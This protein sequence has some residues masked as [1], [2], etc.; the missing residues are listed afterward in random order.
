M[1]ED[2]GDIWVF[3]Y[4]SLMW[5]PGFDHVEARPALLRGYHRALCVYSTQ[6]R[7]KP[8]APGLVLGLDRGGACMGRAFRIAAMDIEDSMTY[9]DE[10]EMSQDTYAPKD[11]PVRLDDGRRVLAH[12]YVVRRDQ[13]QYT[14]KLSLDETVDLVRQGHGNRGSARDYLANTVAHLDAMGIADGPL[15]Q[16]LEAVEKKA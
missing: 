14:G 8:G 12:C 1:S 7:G 16:I 2:N 15:H 4:G 9:L 3:G 10:R 5:H 11:L 6:Y 13:D